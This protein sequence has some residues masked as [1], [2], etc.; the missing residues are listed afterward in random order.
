MLEI[1][2]IIG[3]FKALFDKFFC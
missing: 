3:V 2:G 1:P